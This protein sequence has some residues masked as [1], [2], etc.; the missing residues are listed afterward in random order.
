MQYIR[1]HIFQMPLNSQICQL[2]LSL[3]AFILRHFVSFFT[4]S[5][6]F[7][8]FLFSSLHILITSY[9]LYV[10]ASHPHHW[11]KKKNKTFFSLQIHGKVDDSSQSLVIPWLLCFHFSSPI[12]IWILCSI[13]SYRQ[14]HCP[15]RCERRHSKWCHHGCCI[16]PPPFSR[17]LC[18]GNSQKKKKKCAL[19]FW[20]SI[21]PKQI[22]M[23]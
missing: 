23:Q 20:K 13:L 1:W 8:N 7:K 4:N 14:I 22:I 18:R 21:Q 2:P 11:L 9:F 15:F 6:Y 17:L 16:A 10:L 12:E 19:F 3:S 5:L